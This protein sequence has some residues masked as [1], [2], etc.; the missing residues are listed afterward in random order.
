MNSFLPFPTNQIGLY[1]TLL[2]TVRILL[3]RPYR[4]RNRSMN[5]DQQTHKAGHT[6]SITI[7]EFIYH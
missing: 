3:T 5:F 2:T 7:L 4:T 1:K 6:T